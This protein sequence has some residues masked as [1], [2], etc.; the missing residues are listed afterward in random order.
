MATPV[1]R[2]QTPRQNELALAARLRHIA[3]LLER[4]EPKPTTHAQL[5]MGYRLVRADLAHLEAQVQPEYT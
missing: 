1:N 3:N 2:T 4:E 5:R